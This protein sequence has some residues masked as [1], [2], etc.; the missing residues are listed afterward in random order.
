MSMDAIEINTAHNTKGN[1]AWEDSM[2]QNRRWEGAGNANLKWDEQH[3]NINNDDIAYTL[4]NRDV[5]HH[6]ETGF[7]ASLVAKNNIHGHRTMNFKA[8]SLNELSILAE[9]LPPITAG[10][11][12]WLQ[13]V[14]Y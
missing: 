5:H 4:R 12:Q 7:M 2:G 10:G 14:N 13:Q 3:D 9:Q 6:R 1:M 8:F 11:V